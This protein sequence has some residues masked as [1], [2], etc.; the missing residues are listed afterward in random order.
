MVKFVTVIQLPVAAVVLEWLNVAPA[1]DVSRRG[2]N[3]VGE[4][5][6]NDARRVA[7]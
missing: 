7:D 3:F 2:T 6:S 1:R 5:A 4:I